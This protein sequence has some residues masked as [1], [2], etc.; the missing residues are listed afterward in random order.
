MALT[1]EKMAEMTGWIQQ[2]ALAFQNDHPFWPPEMMNHHCDLHEEWVDSLIESKRGDF[3]IF[4][5]G[6]KQSDFD[7]LLNETFTPQVWTANRRAFFTLLH[8]HA[9]TMEAEGETVSKDFATFYR[10]R[11]NPPFVFEVERCHERC[12]TVKE[13]LMQNTWHPNRIQK[14]LDTGGHELLDAYI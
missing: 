12:A 4:V 7:R 9:R 6:A 3:T 13:E 1:S 8:K 10:E 11:Y 2:R 5:S 14:I